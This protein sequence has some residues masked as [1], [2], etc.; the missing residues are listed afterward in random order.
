MWQFRVLN[1]NSIYGEAKHYYTAEA[2]ET[3]GRE[4][5]REKHFDHYERL[6]EELYFE[7]WIKG[8]LDVWYEIKDQ[9]QVG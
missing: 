5:V 4:W 2:A 7:G 8:A 6:D 1:N 9:V 3:A